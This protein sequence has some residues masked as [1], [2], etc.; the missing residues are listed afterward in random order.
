MAMRKI[1][2]TAAPRP[3]GTYSQGLLAGPFCFTAGLGPANPATGEVVGTTIEE[4]TRQTLENLGA[5]L[6]AANLNFSNVVKATV[7]LADL[8][9]DFEGFDRV[10][11]QYF[12]EPFPVRTTV[13][14]TLNRILVEIDFVALVEP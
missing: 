14:S 7:H 2:T 10:Y 13:G 1:Q 3:G 4:Q 6:R 11:R 8:P 5:I 12:S 9:R